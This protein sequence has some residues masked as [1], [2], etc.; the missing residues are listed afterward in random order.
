MKINAFVFWGLVAFFIIVDAVYL[1]WGLA[2]YGAVEW[3]G[4]VALGLCALLSGLIA[5]YL[6][7]HYRAAGTA[8]P[9]DRPDSLIDDEDPEMG[10]FSPWSWWP[11][12]LGASC[13]VVFLGFAVGLW[14]SFIGAGLVVVSLVGWT[15]EYYR[16][17]FAR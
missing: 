4:T 16:G 12:V 7:V 1:F 6:T 15:Y 9:Q 3:A 17:F 14:I 13:F 10:F 8:M 5:F 2:Y 11:F